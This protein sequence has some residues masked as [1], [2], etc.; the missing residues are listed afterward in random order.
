MKIK[1]SSYF[2]I[3]LILVS[4]Y[5]IGESLTFGSREAS[6]VPLMLS[7]AIFVMAAVELWKEL[8]RKKAKQTPVTF[9]A[10]EHSESQ[11]SRGGVVLGWAMGFFLGIYLLGFLLAIPLFIFSYLKFKKRAWLVAILLPVVITAFIYCV[12]EIGFQLQLFRGKIL[13]L[14]I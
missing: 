3:C 11:L 5:F 4:L 10:S 12:F 14:I 8:P 13:E 7:C 1:H 2:L 9:E 6:M